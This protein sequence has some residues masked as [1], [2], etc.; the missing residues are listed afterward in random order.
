MEKNLK[1]PGLPLLP[2]EYNKPSIPKQTR[3]NICVD[4]SCKGKENC[5]CL[6][7]DKHDLCHRE[8]HPTICITRICTQKCEHCC[9]KCSPN[10]TKV[11]AFSVARR[12]NQFCHANNIK[13]INLSSGEFICHPQW[14]QIMNMLVKGIKKVRIVTNGDWAISDQAVNVIEFLETN[15]QTYIALSNDRWHTNKN[16]AKATKL[17]L[18]AEIPVSIARKEETTDESIVPVGRAEDS[19]ISTHYNMFSRY[20]SKPS[21]KYSFLID[22][23]GEISKC[24]FGLWKY[25]NIEEYLNGGFDKR[26]KDFNI[27]FYKEFIGSCK[28]CNRIYKNYLLKNRRK[29]NKI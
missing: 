8:L 29:Q 18:E 1:T 20:C 6:K 10:E 12:I 15:P 22:E 7:C 28:E 25:D 23:D 19:W 9:F 3:C 16:V 26:F 5:N 14:W 13:R 21:C 11:M 4:P 27:A 17:L 24:P 2:R